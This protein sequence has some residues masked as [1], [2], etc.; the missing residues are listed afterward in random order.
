MVGRGRAAALPD[1]DLAEARYALVAFLDEQVLK[2]N[3]P[4]RAEWMGHPLQLELYN[5]FTAGENF[6]N[7]MRTLL[8][9]GGCSPALEIYY[10]CLML[11]F[12]GAYGISGDH[13]SLASF[14]DAARQRV[15][16]A[17][18]VGPKLGPRAEPPD[19]LSARRAKNWPL[20]AVVIG[21]LVLALLVVVGL[22]LMVD[23]NVE[24][25][26]DAMSAKP[27]EGRP[28]D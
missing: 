14:H 4:G 6:F 8:Q 2:S 16:T 19:R 7:R 3:W 17:W 27:I 10:L 21:S 11:G 13:R 9:Q 5:E 25:S 20:I 15:V 23:S 28:L 12:R 22:E 24:Q 18:P 26:L 1:A